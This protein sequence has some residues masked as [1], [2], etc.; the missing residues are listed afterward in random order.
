M[1]KMMYV[2]VRDRARLK[3]ITEVLIRYGLQDLL[4]IVGLGGL[5]KS[6]LA[7]ND[8]ADIQ[9][10]PQRLRAALEALG[11][12][13]VKFGQIL[14]TRSDLLDQR[15]IDELDKLHSQ[16]QFLPWEAIRDQV[17]RD[18]GGD[19]QQV[20]AEFDL[21]PLAAASMAQIYRARLHSG[22][23]VVVKVL[24]PELEKTIQADLRLLAYLADTAA[25][26]SPMMARFRP[27]QIVRTLEIALNHELDLS[28][29]G[30][31]C[32][33]I[34]DYFRDRPEIV[35]PKIYTQFSS[36]RLLVQQYLPG[37]S[38]SNQAD[39]IAAGFDRPLLARRGAI[40]FMK[41]VL[42]LRLYH[43]D[44]HPGNLMALEGDKV[45]F[46]DFG[47]VGSLSERRRNQLLLL[48]HALVERDTA[49]IVNTLVAWTDT[50]AVDLMDLEL[51]AQNFFD[52]QLSAPMTLGGALTDFLLMAREH[53]LILPSDLVLLFKA[54]IT[55]DGVLHR[56][57]P[58]FDIV[59]T[60]RPML[61]KMML[62]RFSPEATRQRLVNLG[63][64]A[65]EASEELPQTLRLITQR[66]K[67]G[68]LH[69][70]VEIKN[71]SELSRSLERAA[72]TLAI[73]IVTAAF[74]LGI[75]PYL[76]NSTV[77]LWG[78]PLFPLLG[79]TV[80]IAG[81]VLLVLRLRR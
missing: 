34:G 71:L 39:L 48:L 67:S 29:E 62:Q 26:Q 74:A 68:R 72:I 52:R 36:P 53:Q 19:P 66:L 31:N 1:L 37:V 57:D 24:R 69:A 15:W 80:C 49:G 45:G 10:M 4:A 16:A 14:A 60:L 47:M 42:D 12:T 70:G 27:Q 22:E 20:F 44:P 58:Q 35:I 76:M 46:I 78:I 8:E 21:E 25:E 77:N 17:S 51:A 50:D 33:Q 64:E 65:V 40:A 18:L 79:T 75:A 9:T 81:L 54:L 3:Q 23:E 59:A 30:Y 11:P 38:P 56:L 55:A 2:T 63:I 41:M 73:A 32:R 43:A 28:H 61:E 5:V 13:F 6:R 7:A